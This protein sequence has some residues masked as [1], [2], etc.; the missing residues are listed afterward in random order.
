MTRRTWIASALF[1]TTL[2]AAWGVIW[3]CCSEQARIELLAHVLYW[4]MPVVLLFAG[5]TAWRRAASLAR[6][7]PGAVLAAGSCAAVFAVVPPAMR[8]QFDET[9]LASA[10]QGM[11]T[12]RLAVMA[13]GALPYEG[14]VLAVDNMPDKRPPLFAFLTSVL[15]DVLGFRLAN[16]FWVNALALSIGLFAAF[17]AARARLGFAGAAAAPLLL[18]SVP[19]VVVTATSAGF[20]LLATVLFGLSLFAAADFVQRPD[21]PRWTAFVGIAVLFA[22]SRYEA[23]PIAALTAVLVLWLARGRWRP[24]RAALIATALAPGLASPL[25]L[26]LLYARDPGFYPEAGGG[27]LV[28]FGHLAE[29]TLP[30]VRAAFDPALTNPLPGVVA[31]TGVAAWG[32]RLARGR[33]SRLD[34]A[35][36]V[37]VG[38]ATLLALAWFIGDVREPI[39]LR[40]FLPFACAAALLPLLGVALVPERWRAR[41]AVG[42]LIVAAVLAAFRTAAVRSGEAFPRLEAAKIADGLDE[43]LMR[44]AP[45]PATTLWVGT[46]AQHLIVMGHAALTPQAFAA[47]AADVASLRRSGDVRTIYVVETPIDR[48]L[49]RGFGNPPPTCASARRT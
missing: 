33:G 38:T 24:D 46:P 19:I 26:Q 4:L 3:V 14:A 15:H 39:S 40:L 7:W 20:D 30:F 31:I 16:A 18:L 47:H 37:P 45:D 28:S 48:L 23:L 49:P 2:P 41:A 32:W 8:V 17:A 6:Y 21:S 9:S 35:I 11:H 27:A 22:S 5:V 36:G 44:M 10:S 12:Q 42:L 13:T 25:M 34:V 43:M 29:H 1:A